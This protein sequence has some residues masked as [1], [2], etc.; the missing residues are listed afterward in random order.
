MRAISKK[1]IE[2]V[3][4][5]FIAYFISLAGQGVWTGLLTVNL[6][7]TPK[8]PWSVPL[9]AGL[10]WGIWQYLD[11]WGWP[12]R[13]AELRNHYLRAKWLTGEVLGWALLAGGL[14]ITALAGYWM[15]MAKVT[16]LPG[17]GLTNL[18]N[19]PVLTT[20]LAISM[21]SLV[22]PILEQAGFF[23]YGQSFLEQRFPKIAAVLIIAVIYAVGPHPPSGSTVWPRLVFYFLTGL[24]FAMLAYLT[25]S[26][27]PGLVVHIFGILVFFTLI[28]P[29]D[30]ARPLISQVGLDT[31]FW[32]YLALGVISSGLA[33][34]A[35][36]K[37]RRV[38]INDGRSSTTNGK[39]GKNTADRSDAI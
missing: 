20:I 34:M 10:L 39:R 9:M 36:L 38:R 26:I 27:L 5:I 19:I 8:I 30:P 24:T 12:H 37:L 21:G 31:D 29:Y 1:I 11:G 18:S 16:R 13:T 7:I 15:I 14:S 23:G 25:Q 3:W 4:A 22:S 17:N 33:I 28:W 35:F 2:L 6:S 32:I